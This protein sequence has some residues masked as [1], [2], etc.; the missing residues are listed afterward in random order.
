MVQGYSTFFALLKRDMLVFLPTWKDR[1]I[2]ALIWGVLVSVIFEYVMPSMGFAGMGQFMGLGTVASWG[3]FEVTEIISKFIADLE[4]ERS[5]S[6]YLTLP[7]SQSAVFLRIAL[8]N[9]LQSMAI[10]IF[11]IPIFMII[12]PDGFCL[13]NF[14][15]TKFLLIFLV[16]HL[17]YGTF[18]LYLASKIES[19]N[20]MSNVWMRIV[21]PLWWLGCYQFT[22]K[23]LYSV[24]PTI[25][26]CDLL[27]PMVY[28][29]EGM[30]AAVLGQ[31]GFINFWACFF[32][33]L[34][35]TVLLGYLGI[36]GLKKRLDCL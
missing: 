9:A 20:K 22:W 15:I 31:D 33:L 1:F 26:V 34:L 30:R 23:V 5:I 28:T 10:A 7:I 36:K 27:N 8:A 29:M 12:L 35:Y 3:F 13:T 18:S 19:F 32:V 4:G 6:Y 25:A 2:N 16:I 17:F 21:Y 11:F 24:A 14:C